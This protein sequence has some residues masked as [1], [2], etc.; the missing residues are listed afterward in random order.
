MAKITYFFREAFRA[1]VE[2]KLMTF[3]S[4]FT[5]AI[6][7]FFLTVAYFGMENVNR[8]VDHY[9]HQSS[10]VA[11]FQLDLPEPQQTALYEL[12]AKDSAVESAKLVTRAEAYGLF[13]SLYGK[14]LLSAVEENPFPASVEIDP[15]EASSLAQLEQRI[16]AMDGVE[17]VSVS[18]EWLASLNQ[19]QR[20]LQWGIA[21]LIVI[22]LLALY[23]T[24]TNTIKLTVY[25][26]RELV[27]NMQYV[28]ASRSYICTPFI[29][30][31]MIQGVA[32]AV[33]AW[34]GV[35]TIAVL[36]SKFSLYWGGTMLLPLM[37][38]LGGV[39][40]FL[41]SLDAVRKFVK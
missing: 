36:L 13:S 10:V 38:T 26:R 20:Y 8:W 28:G 4:I 6:T 9:N 21:A 40:G 30:E 15:R 22:I 17:S 14:E 31:G 19:F 37:L 24:I 32:G 34:F 16:T 7:L 35:E 11:Y 39:L 2:A 5:V 33:L 12:I 1:L 27:V 3:V 18:K 41:G 25:A 23:F 29:L